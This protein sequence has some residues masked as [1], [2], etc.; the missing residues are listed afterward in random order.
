MRAWR[1]VR[2]W[3][4]RRPRRPGDPATMLERGPAARRPRPATLPPGAH[5]HGDE[6]HLEAHAHPH[7]GPPTDGRPG[8]SA[9]WAPARS[10]P[11][12]GSPCSRA[13]WQVGAVASRDPA[14]RERFRAAR[15]RRAGFAEAAALLDECQLAILA[16]PDDARRRLAARAPPV[17][18]PGASSTRAALHGAEVLAPGAGRRARRPARSTRWSPSP[19]SSGRSPPCPGRRRDRGRRRRSLGAPRRDGRRRSAATPVRLAPGLQG[20]LPR[21]RRPRRR[22]PD[23][24]PRRGR[25]GRPR[26]P[27]LDEAG[28]LADL[29]PARRADAR[30][31]PGARASRRRSPGPA[32]R[33]D[34]GTVAAHLAALAADAPDVAL[35]RLPGRW[36]APGRAI[37]EARRGLAPEAAARLRA[38]LARRP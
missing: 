5:R 29:R 36:P 15:A 37:A 38:A 12:S 22:R 35:R 27:G 24:A 23:G 32:T 2:A 10:A 17:L 6:V 9:S 8:A 30:Q 25:R 18:G 20:R 3:R 31:R 19:T 33:G 26:R 4:E 21:G 7:V 16:V 11:R 28:A 14:R 13:G 1:H 34:A